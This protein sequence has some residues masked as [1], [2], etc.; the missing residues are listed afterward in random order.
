MP[1]KWQ[2]GSVREMGRVWR[3]GEAFLQVTTNAAWF[4]TCNNMGVNIYYQFGSSTNTP[5]CLQEFQRNPC[6]IDLVLSLWLQV[7]RSKE[8]DFLEA[9]IQFSGDLLM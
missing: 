5:L 9:S 4:G 7:L 2:P 8:I 3:T 6:I 1:Q